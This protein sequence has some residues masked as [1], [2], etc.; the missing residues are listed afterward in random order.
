MIPFPTSRNPRQPRGRPLTLTAGL[1]LP[2]D[3][4]AEP[5]LGEGAVVLR[6]LR[7]PPAC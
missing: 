7:E 5:G 2:L 1:E 4:L 6:S 3:D